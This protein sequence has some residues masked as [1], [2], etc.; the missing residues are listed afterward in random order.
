MASETFALIDHN[1]NI[2]LKLTNVCHFEIREPVPSI[3]FYLMSACLRMAGFAQ[4]TSEK[5]N[6]G[7]QI[8]T[9][10][11]QCPVKNRFC[12]IKSLDGWTVCP[13]VYAGNEKS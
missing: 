6:A 2:S 1:H 13:G 8:T 9:G 10:Q 11:L 4:R 5:V 12:L 7:L 3:W